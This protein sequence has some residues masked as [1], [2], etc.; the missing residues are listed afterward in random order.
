MP[1]IVKRVTQMSD[2]RELI[3]FDDAD[4]TLSPDRKPDTRAP[5]PRPETPV[6]R[7]DPLT[8][9]WISIAAARQNRAFLPPAELDPLAP[10]TPEYATEIPDP[11]DVAVFEN[12]SPSFG[13]GL[14]RESSRSDPDEVRGELT[15]I[16]VGR[17]LPGYGRCE[18]VCFSPHRT[19]SWADFSHSRART[20]VEAWADRTAA[21]SALPG[22]QQV[23]PFENRGP[24]IGVTL[25][26]P[27]GQIYAFPYVTPKTRSLLASVAH[28]GPGLMQDI[29]DFERKSERKLLETEHFTVFVPFAARWPLEVHMLAH[30]QFPDLAATTDEERE[31]IAVLYPRIL[32]ALDRLYDTPTPYIAAWHQAPV[33]QG[34]ADIR[35]ML[36]VTSPRRAQDKLKYTAGS[37]TGMGA[38]IGDI[39]PEAAAARLQEVL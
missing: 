22:I 36:Q 26:H 8:G 23:Y 15:A 35:L 34:R 7:Q 6:I 20:V 30:R 16:G 14:P 39:V 1:D 12:K 31:E 13:P 18:V 25:H 19:G 10:S 29:L 27:H 2:G 9:E 17:A 21:L 3:Y 32:T 28:Y 11:Y 24:E 37:E 33:H 4:T 5:Q 38:F